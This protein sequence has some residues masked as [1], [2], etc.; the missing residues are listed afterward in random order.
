MTAAVPTPL[1][2]LRRLLGEAERRLHEGGVDAPRLNAECLLAEALGVDRTRL[3]A[4][5]PE[6]AP[7][8]ATARFET[9]LARRLRREP[10]SYVLGH[11]EFWSLDFEVDPSVLIPRP[12][13][14]QIIELALAAFP[15]ARRGAPVTVCDIGTGSGCLAVTLAHEWPAARVVAVDLSP[16]AL[17][18]ARRNARRC[19][20]E[21]RLH[22]VVSDLLD[23][24]STSEKFHLI[25]SNPPYVALREAAELEPELGWEPETA[26]FGGTD[27]LD[28]IRRLLPSV[29]EHLCPG[30]LFLMEIGAGQGED[31]LALARE[32]GALEAE[33]LPDLA[34]LPRMLRARWTKED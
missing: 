4:R 1:P 33:V 30:G 23:S 8:D 22:F 34:G 21:G 17:H 32:A 14:E 25:V 18:L 11:Q 15:D 31:V 2:T 5:L 28:I 12:E 20:V 19:G 29:P 7:A 10:L 9:L 24:L 6:L 27:G 13:T 3:L 26:L 16:A